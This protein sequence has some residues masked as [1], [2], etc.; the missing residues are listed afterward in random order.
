MKIQH[1]IPLFVCPA[2]AFAQNFTA[3]KL[4]DNLV[5]PEEIGKGWRAVNPERWPTGT[6]SH[7]VA[8][9][10]LKSEDGKNDSVIAD[11]F[12]FQTPEQ[13]DT[14]LDLRRKQ[15]A[16]GDGMIIDDL[17]VGK[18]AFASIHKS[19]KEIGRRVTFRCRNVVITLSPS[20]HSIEIARIFTDKLK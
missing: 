17:S 6:N 13:A 4:V 11:M 19:E 15:I 3:K 14:M 2:I 16:A 7:I 10:E 1:Y 12:L 9:Y 5:L 8:M 18:G 20:R